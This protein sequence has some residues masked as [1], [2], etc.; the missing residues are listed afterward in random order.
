M[1]AVTLR[2]FVSSSTTRRLSI[3]VVAG[4]ALRVAAASVLSGGLNA[5]PPSGA[6]QGEYVRVAWNLALGKGYVG[7]S[8]DVVGED[9]IAREHPTAWRAP[10]APIV[11]ALVF[12]LTGLR[13]DV[14]RLLQCLVSALTIPMLYGVGKSCFN[15]RVGWLAAVAYTVWP[16]SLVFSTDLLGESLGTFWL[17]AS[18]LVGIQCIKAPSWRLSVIAGV[19]LGLACLTRPNAATFPVLICVW[20]IWQYARSW[21]TMAVMLAIPVVSGLVVLPWTVRNAVVFGEFI[22]FT[23]Q[24]GAAL[25]IANNRI[26]ATVP[27]YYGY[28]SDEWGAPEYRPALAAPNDEIGRAKV[29]KKLANEWLS[30]N[31]D[32]WWFLVRNRFIRSWSP[33]LAPHSPAHYRWAMLASWGPVLLLFIPAFVATFVRAATGQRTYWILHVVILHFVLNTVF[34]IGISRYRFPIE[35]FCLVFAAVTVDWMLKMVGT[36]RPDSMCSQ[37]DADRR[38]HATDLP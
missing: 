18:V 26:V 32:K 22:P 37:D 9:G 36:K 3:L 21:K 14:V 34:F 38:C 1:H 28:S 13:Y 4:F 7:I 31:R 12:Q 10:G 24:G 15:D 35:G 6:D 33:F 20:A 11:W 2:Q 16:T 17:T 23:T 27:K 30:N 5:K 19:L 8:P 29:A 25:M